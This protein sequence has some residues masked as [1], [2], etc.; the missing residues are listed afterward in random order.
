MHKLVP[1]PLNDC[2]LLTRIAT[3]ASVLDDERNGPSSNGDFGADIYDEESSQQVHGP[4]THKP[5]ERV[6]PLG[7]FGVG[8]MYIS[9]VRLLIYLL[10]TVYSMTSGNVLE[11]TVRARTVLGAT[12][13]DYS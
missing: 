9:C 12:L 7:T 1:W 4:Q 10:E 3:S 6:L 2:D 5:H 8:G 11:S 13:E